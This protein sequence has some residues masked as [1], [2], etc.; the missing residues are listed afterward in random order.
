VLLTGYIGY[1]HN[2]Y[3]SRSE[4]ELLTLSWKHSQIQ[5]SDEED[6]GYQDEIFY[7]RRRLVQD[8]P[9][10]HRGHPEQIRF[11]GRASRG[12][13]RLKYTEEYQHPKCLMKLNVKCLENSQSQEE[14]ATEKHLSLEKWIHSQREWI[15]HQQ[16]QALE[17]AEFRIRQRVLELYQ[18]EQVQ[19]LQK[20]PSIELEQSIRETSK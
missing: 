18:Q 5:A 9:F 4:R 8:I 16:E 1:P 17:P 3:N 15:V 6:K 19:L 11:I 20:E 2:F 13:A 7:C 10:G 12:I 14:R